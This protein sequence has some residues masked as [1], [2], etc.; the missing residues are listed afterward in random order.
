LRLLLLVLSAFLLATSLLYAIAWVL[1][2]LLR[3]LKDA[4]HLSVRAVP[5]FAA[6]T[7]LFSFFSASK[8]LDTLGAFGFWSVL[9][10]LGTIAFPALSLV[11]LY[12]AVRAPRSEIHPA[13]RILSWLVSLACCILTAFLA[14]W[15]LLAVRLWA[16]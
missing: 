13:I 11:G 15:H 8:S 7:L 6:L 4:K 12:P 16:S 1:L 5:F 9:F 10:F 14:S 3:R 2:W